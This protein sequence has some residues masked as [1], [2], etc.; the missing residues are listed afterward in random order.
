MYNYNCSQVGG[1]F[2]KIVA[3]PKLL[4]L[5]TSLLPWMWFS[6]KLLFSSHY[7]NNIRSTDLKIPQKEFWKL[8]SLKIRNYTPQIK[9]L[10]VEGPNV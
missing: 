3:W 6:F 2:V 4:R 8:H 10:F 1:D 7:P 9:R 5:T